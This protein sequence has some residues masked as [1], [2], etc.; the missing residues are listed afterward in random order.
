[1]HCAVC[2][3]TR[4]NIYTDLWMHALV[5]VHCGACSIMQSPNSVGLHASSKWKQHGGLLQNGSPVPWHWWHQ[6]R[7]G[8]TWISEYIRAIPCLC[9]VTVPCTCCAV[10]WHMSKDGMSRWCCEVSLETQCK[11][12][13]L[14]RAVHNITRPEVYNR[15]AS[16]YISALVNVH[17]AGRHASAV[18][19]TPFGFAWSM[20][21]LD[22]LMI[23]KG[24]A[25]DWRWH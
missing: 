20:W 21:M 7:V 16:M 13:N 12:F 6:W 25:S 23:P 4:L 10:E 22:R 15:S 9:Y 8:P 14:Q 2:T 17:Q 19:R 24:T 3:L 11:C 5:Y 18:S 1:M